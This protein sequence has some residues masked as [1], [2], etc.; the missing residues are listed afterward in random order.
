MPNL[1][2]LLESI[3]SLV[4]APKTIVSCPATPVEIPGIAAADAFEAN[5]VFGTLVELDVPKSGVIISATFW[6]LDDESTQIDLEIFKRKITQTA[7]DAAWAPSDTDLLHFVTELA[8]VIGDDHINSYT[9]DLTNIG[10][11]YTA[12]EGKFWIQAVCRSTPTIAAGSMPRFQLQIQSFDPKF[13][14]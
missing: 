12:P 3:E 10:K 7:S 14:G 5:D 9:F 4:F 1:I 6:D 2:E 8:F 11:A 13:E